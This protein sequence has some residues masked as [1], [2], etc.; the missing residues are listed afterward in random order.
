MLYHLLTELTEYISVF[1]VSRYITFRALAALL[2]ALGISFLLS[3]WFI[4]K[5]K[6]KQIGQ[7]VRDDGPESHFSKAG[8]PTMGGGL[9]LFATLLP[10]LLWM[11]WGN[12]LLWYV[13]CITLIYG[14][15]GFL[16]D[17]LKISKKN[18]K[19]LSGKMKLVTQFLTAG[20]ACFLYYQ[21]TG[22]GDL[23]FLSLIH[24]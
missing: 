2:T 9:I 20:V 23:H 15:V 16:D 5:L 8:T 14:M 7:Q 1:N 19:G 18:T 21:S 17:Y 13:S 12:P 3:P 10:A 6:S 24:I 11:D 22:N 4:R